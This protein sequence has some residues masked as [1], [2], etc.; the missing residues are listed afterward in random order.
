MSDSG[1]VIDFDG[2]FNGEEKTP[3]GSFYELRS[4]PVV[5]R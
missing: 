5:S 3:V 2:A 1:V 4:N